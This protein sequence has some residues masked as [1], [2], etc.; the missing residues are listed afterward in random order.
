MLKVCIAF[1]AYRVFSSRLLWLAATPCKCCHI[2]GC[3][4]TTRA[5]FSLLLCYCCNDHSL[6]PSKTIELHTVTNCQVKQIEQ[7][8]EKEVIWEIGNIW[9]RSKN[10]H[11]T[12]SKAIILFTSNSY[13]GTQTNEQPLQRRYNNPHYHQNDLHK[14]SCLLI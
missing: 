2:W 8:K 11:K 7:V 14:L 13:M 3:G 1:Y 9:K 5:S 4:H 12:E 10:K 6:Y